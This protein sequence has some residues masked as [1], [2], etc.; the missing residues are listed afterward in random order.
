MSR[1]ILKSYFEE[2]DEPTEEEIAELIDESLNLPDDSDGFTGSVTIK[3]PNH[4]M[5]G[6][7]IENTDG[8]LVTFL[9]KLLI[10]FDPATISINSAT[11]YVEEGRSNSIALSGAVT[12]ND[13]NSFG[14]ARIEEL[15]GAVT[16]HTF[17]VGQG[18]TTPWNKN[19]TDVD[20]NKQYQAKV[21]VDNDG[22]PTT[23]LSAI[24]YIFAVIPYIYGQDASILN[25]STI[26][27]AAEMTVAVN[28]A[29]LASATMEI[30]FDASNQYLHFCYPQSWGLP[31]S[32][33]DNNGFQQ[34]YGAVGSGEDW[35]YHAF[36]LVSPYWEEDM[37]L[38]VT[39][40]TT[41]DGTFTFNF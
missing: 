29:L 35:E 18:A 7:T 5:Y 40:P 6:Q 38:F 12:K 26:Y 16:V 8:N 22:D 3:N 32:I 2:G 27:D 25:N 37:Y 34:Y 33:F 4:P 20:S 14:T 11:E 19:V 39:G 28:N 21:D 23:I 15:L 1:N 41:V 9:K 17:A 24:K 13:E 36:N 31:T 10:P 30:P